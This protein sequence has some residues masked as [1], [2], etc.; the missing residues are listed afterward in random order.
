MVL[1]TTT[2]N[3]SDVEINDVGEVIHI[4]TSARFCLHQ[5]LETPTQ[6]D[7]PPFLKSKLWLVI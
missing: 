7:Y 5:H 4:H 2:H 1:L 3:E 6:F